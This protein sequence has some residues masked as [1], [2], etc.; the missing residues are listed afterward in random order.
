MM[1][2]KENDRVV[3]LVG[4]SMRRMVG[5]ARSVGLLSGV[6]PIIDE[7][8]AQAIPSG[9]VLY[10]CT[11]SQGE[12]RAALSR[13]AN[14]ERRHVK[15]SRGDV[16]IFSSKIIPGNEKTI[17]RLQNSLAEDGV[18]IVT[19]KDRPIHVSGHP[20]QDEL[21]Q[22][23]DWVKP[24]IAIPVHGERRHLLEHAELAKKW[25]IPHA[26]DPHN[27]EM[28]RLSKDGAEVVDIVPSG[29]LHEDAG[30]IV[31]ADDDSLRQRR[32]MA[33]AGHISISLV[34]NTKGKIISGPEPRISGFPLGP[35]GDY[36]DD[37][38]DMVADEAEDAFDRISSKAR[39]DEDTVEERIR[40]K[41]KRLVNEKTD[42]RAIVEVTAHRI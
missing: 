8:E 2:A 22:M 38:L 19:E 28:I 14:G 20:Y 30:H 15:F 32:K 24:H 37:L 18:H 34:Y 26:Y 6:G 31:R 27:G 39:Q 9:N 1:A 41:V 3:C 25:G 16:V 11:G 35:N 12:A 40:S 36:L 4:R 33:Y 17:Y 10:I 29:R 7:E 42:K 23:Y 13:I 21:K 5:A